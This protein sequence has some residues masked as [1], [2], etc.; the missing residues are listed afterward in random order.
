MKR[1]KETGLESL[2]LG[3]LGAS[4]SGDVRVGP[5]LA[6]PAVLVELGVKPWRALSTARVDP[7]V[8]RHPESR[9]AL[10]KVGRLLESCV[11]LTHCSHFGLLV[12]ER[13]DLKFFGALGYLMR[14]SATVGD[15]L[16]SLLLHL[17]LHD[18]GGTPVLLAPNASRVILG[19]SLY[20]HN[21]PATAQI[22]DTVIAIAYRIL[23]E[24]CG[25]SWRPLRVQF[26]H[27]PPNSTI[28]Y[29]RLFG[30]S[31]SF[32]AEFSRIVF[33]SSWLEAPIDGADA[34]LHGVLAKAIREAE[35]HS[36]MS[37]TEHVEGVLH[38]TLLS[39]TASAD[40]VARVFGISE[41]TLRRRLAQ[42]GNNLRQLIHNLVALSLLFNA[43]V[44]WH[45]FRLW[46][47]DAKRLKLK[48]RPLDLFGHQYTIDEIACLK[49]KPGE[50]SP[51]QKEVLNELIRD[52]Q[53]LR[54]WIHQLSVSLIVP[55]GT[56]TYYR[57]QER[58]LEDALRA[59]RELRGRLRGLDEPR[60]SC[61]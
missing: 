13:F 35:A 12:G 53:L 4:G 46:R 55:L 54:P 42:E 40:A 48:E 9:I 57:H 49:P 45:R 60:R 59:L 43:T 32:D 17:H 14:N 36:P 6:L 50:F 25:A 16:L 61:A 26:S 38:R 7:A 28:P 18:R 31:V 52:I 47:I 58:L 11:A 51:R 21:M 37:F 56:E 2:L 33:T 39:G 24:L 29:R 41:R 44:L 30:S 8:F 34:R 10:D 19:Y 1:I 15:A 22:Y 27:S 3:P 5:I 20:S 23:R